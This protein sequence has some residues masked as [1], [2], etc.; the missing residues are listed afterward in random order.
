M[1]WEIVLCGHVQGSNQRF[2]KVMAYELVE[3]S[4]S[5]DL[6]QQNTHHVFVLFYRATACLLYYGLALALDSMPGTLAVKFFLISSIEIP[7][8][9]L[10]MLLVDVVGRKPL[11]VAGFLLGTYQDIKVWK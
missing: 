10:Y 6:D 1:L 7:S 5:P 9:I 3:A 8:S 4:K 2:A 11:F